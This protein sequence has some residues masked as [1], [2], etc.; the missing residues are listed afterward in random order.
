M[1]GLLFPVFLPASLPVPSPFICRGTDLHFVHWSLC[2]TVYFLS[3]RLALEDKFILC[4]HHKPT[5][6]FAEEMVGKFAV[7]KEFS[8]IM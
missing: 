2:V 4:R 7:S 3:K 1:S 5:A 6:S 8:L